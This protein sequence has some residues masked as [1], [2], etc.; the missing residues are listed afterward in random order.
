V[1][2]KLRERL[3]QRNRRLEKRIDK[4]IVPPTPAIQTP[5]LDLQ[6]AD[7]TQAIAAGGLCPIMQMIKTLELRELINNAIPIFKLYAPYDE[8]DHVLNIALNL[9]AGGTCLDHLE[10]RRTDEA[11]LNALGAQRIP[12]PTTAGDFCRR[13]DKMKI[14][15]LQQAI[16][17]ARLKVWKQ[18]PAEFFERAIIEADGTMVETSGQRKEG[19]GMNYKKQWGYHPLVVTL[20]NTQEVLYMHNRSGN[21][22]SHENSGFYFDRSIELCRKAGFLEILLR[23]D[24]DFA[25]TTKF[26]GWDNDHVKFIFGYDAKPNLV[27]IAESL[28]NEAWKPLRRRHPEAPKTAPRAKRPNYKQEIIEENEYLDKRLIGEWIAEFEYQPNNCDRPY[29]M[30][31]VRKLIETSQAGERLFEDYA[32]FF[33]VTNE[34]KT[35]C[36]ARQVVFHAN[37]RCDQEN[38]ISQLHASG[39]LSAPLDN[40]V[41]NEA[42]MVIASLAWTLKC[43]SGLMI[44]PEGT[45]KQK[46]QQAEMKTRIIRMEF[47][48][49]LQTIIQIPAQIIR[50]SRRLIYRLLTFRASA[51]IVFTLFAQVSRPLRC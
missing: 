37:D 46:E 1:N 39:A 41:S 50:S 3:Q 9:L 27:D 14:L 35:Q 43:W 20:A 44:R 45:A 31:A 8:A 2:T 21:R 4:K 22:P 49:Y 29:R 7:R 36:S 42:Y 30:V 16:N 5:T 33:Y 12:D 51:E 47:S 38:T 34:S 40:L 25:L 26:D 15:M 48:T 18:Q 6:L 13:F 24:T 28:E 32:Y 10:I 23:G 19:I 17:D 11:Y